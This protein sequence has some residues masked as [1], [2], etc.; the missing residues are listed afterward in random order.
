MMAPWTDDGT[1]EDDG[2]KDLTEHFKIFAGVELTMRR[3]R[4]KGEV[5]LKVQKGDTENKGCPSGSHLKC[6]GKPKISHCAPRNFDRGRL[7][8]SPAR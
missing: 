2:K 8:Y 3:V 6:C 7:G 5:L 4:K 1:M